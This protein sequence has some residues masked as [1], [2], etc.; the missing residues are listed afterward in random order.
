MSRNIP[1]VNNKNQGDIE[2]GLSS[3]DNI[4]S[5]VNDTPDNDTP[6]NDTP[7]NDTPDNDTPVTDKK[8]GSTSK[9]PDSILNNKETPRSVNSVDNGGDVDD[10]GE[11]DESLLPK[12]NLKDPL[13]IN[14]DVGL[15]LQAEAEAKAQAQ[16]QA[17]ANANVDGDAE[18]TKSL[19]SGLDN[20]SVVSD[21]YINLS[22]SDLLEKIEKRKKIINKYVLNNISDKYLIK[23]KKNIKEIISKTD[24]FCENYKKLKVEVEHKNNIKILYDFY[25]CLAIITEK[26]IDE[27]TFLYIEKGKLKECNKKLENTL[28]DIKKIMNEFNN[29]NDRQLEELRNSDLRMVIKHEKEFN[30]HLNKKLSFLNERLDLLQMKYNEYKKWYDR[31]NIFIIIISTVLSVFESFRLEVEDL[32]PPNSHGLELFFNMLPIGISSVITCS[33]AIIKF[34]KY[35]EKMENMQ[36]TREKVITSISRIENIKESLWFNDDNDFDNIKKN[37]LSEVFTAFNESTSE[38]QRHLKYDDPHKFVKNLNEKNKENYKN[39]N[40]YI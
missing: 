15:K 19:I 32:I 5:T 26:Y 20:V 33:A 2:E 34:R 29:N 25:K 36:F 4:T 12:N 22:S 24:L 8:G 31:T 9:S 38:L 18:T 6:V 17:Q 40:I 23:I 27:K 1:G 28:D 37:Y 11:V 16:A 21:N 14:A 13:K 30:D 35:Q 39:K 7:D 10:R 3:T